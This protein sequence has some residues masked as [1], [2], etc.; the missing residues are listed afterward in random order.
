MT[1]VGV[2]EAGGLHCEAD[3]VVN[4]LLTYMKSAQ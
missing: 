4:S 3:V 2:A 1:S